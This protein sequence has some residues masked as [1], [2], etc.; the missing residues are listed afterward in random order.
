MCALAQGDRLWTSLRWEWQEVR[1]LE[2]Y[3]QHEEQRQAADKLQYTI[4]PVDTRENFSIQVHSN[5][6]S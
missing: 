3:L 2:L 6:D 1:R 5:V 4:P